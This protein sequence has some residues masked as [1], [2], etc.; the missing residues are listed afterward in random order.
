MH[1][2]CIESFWYADVFLAD[3]LHGFSQNTAVENPFSEK[4][5]AFEYGFEI[6]VCN[7]VEQSKT[8]TKTQKNEQRDQ[9]N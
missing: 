2:Q 8:F 3:F 7:Q 5:L 9:A 6:V 1:T 4:G